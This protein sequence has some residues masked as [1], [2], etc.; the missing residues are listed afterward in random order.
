M[1]CGGMTRLNLRPLSF[2]VLSTCASTSVTIFSILVIV[3]TSLHRK[4]Y[5]AYYNTVEYDYS[6]S[7]YA[8]AI[9]YQASCHEL[10]LT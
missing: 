6:S 1:R 5:N 8:P 10:G 3:E 9:T 7:T 2:V 4:W